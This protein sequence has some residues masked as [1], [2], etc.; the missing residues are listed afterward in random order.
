MWKTADSGDALGKGGGGGM[1]TASSSGVTG[2]WAEMATPSRR[3]SVGARRAARHVLC[4]SPSPVLTPSQAAS[5]YSRSPFHFS[6]VDWLG[7]ERVKCVTR[8]HRPSTRRQSPRLTPPSAHRHHCRGQRHQGLQR[9]TLTSIGQRA[10]HVPPSM[11]GEGHLKLQTSPAH[12]SALSAGRKTN[13]NG[14]DDTRP[15]ATLPPKLPPS[16]DDDDEA[17][18]PTTSRGVPPRRPPPPP[19]NE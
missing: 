13:A 4:P 15:G 16:P 11:C 7:S 14:M 6:K 2:V 8:V 10:P 17:N 5:V 1:K 9:N 19:A 18:M 12:H 3:Y